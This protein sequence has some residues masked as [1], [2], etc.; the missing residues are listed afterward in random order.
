MKKI[1]LFLTLNT[2]IFYGYSQ[3]TIRTNKQLLQRVNNMNCSQQILYLK[4]D[5]L[6]Y[7]KSN[8]Y[9]LLNTL[10]KKHLIDKAEYHSSIQFRFIN[11]SS[12]YYLPIKNV[13]EDTSKQLI[14]PENKYEIALIKVKVFKNYLY[15]KGKLFFLIENVEF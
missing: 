12:V 6:S 2:L 7:G 13:S 4:I 15:N 8:A 11:D 9:E 14:N 5:Y 1:F 3:D 10:D